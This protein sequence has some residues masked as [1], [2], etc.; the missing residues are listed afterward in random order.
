MDGRK[1][2]YILNP[3]EQTEQVTELSSKCVVELKPGDTVSFQT[4]GGGGYGSPFERD[5]NAVLLDVVG[6]KINIQRAHDLYG[7]VIDTESTSVNEIATSN[8]RKQLATSRNS[9]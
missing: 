7:V 3:D 1:A 6:G 8:S 2:F 9:N 5:P 4:P